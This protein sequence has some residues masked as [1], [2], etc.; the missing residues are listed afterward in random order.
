M[1]RKEPGFG[2]LLQLGDALAFLGEQQTVAGQDGDRTRFSLTDGLRT[3]VDGG[4]RTKR[5]PRD[6]SGIDDV[7]DMIGQKGETAGI[8]KD[9]DWCV[10]PRLDDGLLEQRSKGYDRGQFAP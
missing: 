2:L 3:V 7:M 10:E 6:G 9:N 4:V 8:A 5:L 1:A